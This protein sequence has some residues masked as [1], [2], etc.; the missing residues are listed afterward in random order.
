MFFIGLGIG[1]GAYSAYA[2]LSIALLFTVVYLIILLIRRPFKGNLKSNGTLTK[3]SESLQ[4]IQEAVSCVKDVIIYGLLFALVQRPIYGVMITLIVLQLVGFFVNVLLMILLNPWVKKKFINKLKKN[5]VEPVVV[6][7]ETKEE[8]LIAKL[9]KGWKET[10]GNT[11]FAKLK[12]L[13]RPEKKP[14]ESEQ[15]QNHEEVIVPVGETSPES[16][17]QSLLQNSSKEVVDLED[18]NNKQQK[19]LPNQV[20]E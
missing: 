19:E 6:E 11:F 7:E 5:K 13:L 16:D 15:N 3:H 10:E 12:T 20:S 1:I 9:K 4:L 8:S 14:E 17:K 18:E 2:Q